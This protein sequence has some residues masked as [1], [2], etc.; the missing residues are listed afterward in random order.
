MR[1]ENWTDI[2]SKVVVYS[3]FEEFSL[4]PRDYKCLRQSGNGHPW[5]YKRGT[6]LPFPTQIQDSGALSHMVS[7]RPPDPWIRKEKWR[8][9]SITWPMVQSI[10]SM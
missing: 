8:L 1:R 9:T 2:E 3:F 4:G 6:F 10:M 7:A 5:G